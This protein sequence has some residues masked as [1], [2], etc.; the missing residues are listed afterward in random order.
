MFTT[1]L[2]ILAFVVVVTGLTWGAVQLL[3]MRGGANISVA[4]YEITLNALQLVFAFAALVVAVW[5]VLKLLKLLVAVFK[6]LNG[7]ET[8]ISRHFD[9]NR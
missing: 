3:D 7:D 4:G 6:F 2:K 5:L 9:R 8:A 1:F